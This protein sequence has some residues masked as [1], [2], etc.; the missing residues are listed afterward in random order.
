M[1]FP[2]QGDR[3][4]YPAPAHKVFFP[5]AVDAFPLPAIV[6]DDAPIGH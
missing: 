4:I 6:M 3:Q 1:V 2:R 5:Y